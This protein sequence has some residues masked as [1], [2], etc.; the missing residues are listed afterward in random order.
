ML[1]PLIAMESLVAPASDVTSHLYSPASSA[2]TLSIE[3]TRPTLGSVGVVHVTLRVGPP[4]ASQV[5]LRGIP[6]ETLVE[7]LAVRFTI[8][9]ATT[10][11]KGR[12]SEEVIQQ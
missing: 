3:M 11:E 6:W 9:G 4:T 5:K 8:T 7:G 12:E 10:G 2:V 1:S